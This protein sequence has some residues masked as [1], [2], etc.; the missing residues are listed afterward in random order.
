MASPTPAL[1]VPRHSP[2][3]IFARRINFIKSRLKLAD[4]SDATKEHDET[5]LKSKAY[6]RLVLHDYG[7]QCALLQKEL[8]ADISSST[9][10]DVGSKEE[11]GDKAAVLMP[12]AIPD[13][14]AAATTA[15]AKDVIKVGWYDP[16]QY[17]EID[18]AVLFWLHAFLMCKI[19][20]KPDEYAKTKFDDGNG[21]FERVD[22]HLGVDAEL[23]SPKAVLE[24]KLITFERLQRAFKGTWVVSSGPHIKR[25]D[26]VLVLYG[27]PFMENVLRHRCTG[28]HDS[29]EI[30]GD[31][32][33]LDS[34]Q[35]PR[36]Q[37]TLYV[38][39]TLRHTLEIFAGAY[40][41]LRS[42]RKTTMDDV[43]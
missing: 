27:C 12:V 28:G 23:L 11:G 40:N 36:D 2:A 24:D 37:R 15:P 31:Y 39:L 33:A 13:L 14:A 42:I 8:Q 20:E 35:P 6:A 18:A 1:L 5:M 19:E 41:T 34:N 32:V 10:L 4:S 3:G 7:G 22:K 29:I 26:Q 16:A 9:L 21:G 17:Q 30:K 38:S 25:F 43:L